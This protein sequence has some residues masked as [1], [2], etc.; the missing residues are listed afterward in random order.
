MRSSHRRIR[1]L[2][3]AFS[4]TALAGLGA[5]AW[6][7]GQ[8]RASLPALDGTQ[9]LAGLTAPA[10]LERDAAGVVTIHGATRIDVARALGFDAVRFA[11]AEIGPRRATNPS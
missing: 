1:I 3:L 2:G 8:L 6:T 11:R 5:V 7:W 4:A 9:S 10:I